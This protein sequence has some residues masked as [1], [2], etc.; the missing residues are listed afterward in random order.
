MS[1]DYP[2]ATELAANMRR[3]WPWL[4]REQA[5]VLACIKIRPDRNRG[6]EHVGWDAM[7]RPLIQTWQSDGWVLHAQLRNGNPTDPK[8]PMSLFHKAHEVARSGK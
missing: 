8:P 1:D 2:G 5:W 7:R 3:R 4:S 6:A